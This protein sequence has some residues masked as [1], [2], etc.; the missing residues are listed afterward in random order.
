MYLALM[1][2]SANFFDAL[3]SRT[4]LNVHGRVSSHPVI[5]IKK[6]ILTN[7]SLLMGSLRVITNYDPNS[8]IQEKSIEILVLGLPIPTAQLFVN[9]TIVA[10]IPIQEHRACQNRAIVF[11]IILHY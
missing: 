8:R 9:L 10:S 6:P 7:L 2:V 4:Y 1:E 3:H 11:N 5:D